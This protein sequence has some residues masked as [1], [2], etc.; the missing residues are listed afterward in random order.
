MSASATVHN[1]AAD[2]WL[3]GEYAE[4][5]HDG[6]WFLRGI[7]PN[8]SGPSRGEVLRVRSVTFGESP[9]TGRPTRMLTFDRWPRSAFPSSSFRKAP[10]P[11]L[12]A[13]IAGRVAKRQS[14]AAGVG[15][16]TIATAVCC[17]AAAVVSQFM[18]DN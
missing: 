15:A 14:E 7:R 3:P 16:V 10:R 18:G 5:T 13:R 2:S 12:R 17:A 9:W 1:V 6:P 4:C 8:R 11:P